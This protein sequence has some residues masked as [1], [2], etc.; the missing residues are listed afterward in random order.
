MKDRNGITLAPGQHVRIQVCVGSYGQVAI[1]EG[2]IVRVDPHS[3]V[4]LRPDRGFDEDCGRF[5]VH[6]RPAGVEVAVTVPR[7][8]YDKFDDFEHGH[9]TWVEVIP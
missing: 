1:R 4:I 5:G 8:G 9:E 2:E 6:H 3:Y 7:D